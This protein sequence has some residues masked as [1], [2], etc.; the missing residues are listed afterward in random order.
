MT[1]IQYQIGRLQVM[2]DAVTTVYPESK[3]A[4]IMAARTV[5]GLESL[6]A[7]AKKEL[8]DTGTISGETYTAISTAMGI[9]E[10]AAWSLHGDYLHETTK[11]FCRQL[12]NIHIMMNAIEGVAAPEGLKCEWPPGPNC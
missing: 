3:P 6:R 8:D 2:A 7:D 11:Q 9:A 5:P 1:Q 4:A 10:D 12:D